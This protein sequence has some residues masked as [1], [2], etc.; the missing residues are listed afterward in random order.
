MVLEKRKIMKIKNGNVKIAKQIETMFN[1]KF[2]SSLKLEY[3][4]EPKTS[5]KLETSII[6]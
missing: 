5:L 1:L 4:Y 3:F 2:Y 6:D